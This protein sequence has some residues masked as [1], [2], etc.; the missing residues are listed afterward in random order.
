MNSDDHEQKPLK[1]W[2]K[3]NCSSLK[4]VILLVSNV[5]DRD[6]N[7]IRAKSTITK[8]DIPQEDVITLNAYAPSGGALNVW[9]STDGCKRGSIKT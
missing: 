3:V 1:R 2:D 4:W 7:V 6:W 5:H 8:G 9:S